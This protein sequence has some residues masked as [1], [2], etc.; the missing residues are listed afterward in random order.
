[1]VLTYASISSH[2][3]PLLPYS[4]LLRLS[5]GE[6]F[7][8]LPP[9]SVAAVHGACDECPASAQVDTTLSDGRVHP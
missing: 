2:S 1:M 3:S 5:I 7:Y 4:A 9:R 6:S 8:T